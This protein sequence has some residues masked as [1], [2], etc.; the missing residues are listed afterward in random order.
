MRVPRA[1]LILALLLLSLGLGGIASGGP[2]GAPA[3]PGIPAAPAFPVGP[4]APVAPTVS[5]TEAT[6]AAEAAKAATKPKP[7]AVPLPP[8]F[9]ERIDVRAVDIEVV[10]TDAKGQ[11]VHGLTA[12]D[13]K[14]L[15]DGREERIDYFAEV[16]EG[17]TTPPASPA[18]AASPAA[19]TAS[20]VR[21]APPSPLSV[22]AGGRVGTSY[23]VFVDDLFPTSVQRNATLSTME[24][25]LALLGPGD[26]M[27]VVAFDGH[28]LTVLSG[29][30]GDVAALRKA[31][32]LAAKRKARGIQ[33]LADRHGDR[34]SDAIDVQD[35]YDDVDLLGVNAYGELPEIDKQ[36]S[37]IARAVT[38]AA[39]AL[40]GMPLPAGRRVM[41]VLAGGWPWQGDVPALQPLTKTA[42][43]LGYT[44]YPVNVQGFDPLAVAADAEA[45]ST[46]ISA[47]AENNY[48]PPIAS[49]WQQ[50]SELTL[51]WLAHATGGMVALNR[52]HALRQVVEDT[53][54]Y[55]WLGFS[56]IWKA[57]DRPHTIRMEVRRPGLTARARSRFF[58]LSHATSAVMTAESILSL[59]GDPA[60]K[61]LV[62]TVG[63]PEPL[64]RGTM[65]LP[66]TFA[67]PVEALTQLPQAASGYPVEGNLS[68]ASLDA[69]G[70]RGT[71]PGRALRVTLPAA[72][73][74]GVF[75]R[76]HSVLRLSRTRQRLV[77]T[78]TGADGAPVWNELEVK[79]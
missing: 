54:S 48:S 11:R 29:W 30:T 18:S 1:P 72:P 19:V 60:R 57:D 53:R 67:I 17:Q 50:S 77:F 25:D 51:K 68:I 65:E 4:L 8:E 59:G 12:A 76:F 43:L 37:G 10:V 69:G 40:R 41:M 31:F 61:R 74:P 79:P 75:V 7:P 71:L 42:N 23:L 20:A 3:S 14:L 63:K 22:P 58:D 38:A 56:P 6:E 62:V 35:V 34:R 66:L 13:F 39:D 45:A 32:T 15:V 44:L 21:A 2:P 26:R 28:G 64:D 27:A 46:S 24:R 33:L 36:A 78:V 16:K 55:Y 9:G 52:D 70:G 73:R 5:A 47:K 49:Y